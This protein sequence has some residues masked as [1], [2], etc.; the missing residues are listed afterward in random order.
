[1]E[2]Q[3]RGWAGMRNLDAPESELAILV[4]AGRYPQG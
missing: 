3:R 2:G 1:M 4:L